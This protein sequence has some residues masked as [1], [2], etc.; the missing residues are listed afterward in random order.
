MCVHMCSCVI[1]CAR[2][3]EQAGS[4]EQKWWVYLFLLTIITNCL[5]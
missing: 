4:Q 3:S 5:K 1:T 2:S